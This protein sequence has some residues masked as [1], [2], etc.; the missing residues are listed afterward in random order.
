MRLASPTPRTSALQPRTRTPLAFWI[1]GLLLVAYV[2]LCA[3]QRDTLWE[4]DGWEHQRA[5]VVL[6]RHLWNPGNPTYATAQPSVRYSPYSV[7]QALLAR[8]TGL[9][10]YTLLSIAAVINTLLLIIGLWCLLKSFGESRAAAA[11]LVVIVG[12]YGAAPGYAGSY[13]LADLPW[14]Q[15]NP[16][17]FSFAL[18]LLAL[19]LFKWMTTRPPGLRL[20][21]GWL[22]LIMLM[23]TATLDHGMNGL[24]GMCV[25]MLIALTRPKE[26]RW[27]WGAAV[28]GVGVAAALVCLAWPWYS[29]WHAVTGQRDNAYWYNRTI[30]V[31]MLVR[32]CAPALLLSLAA[33]LLRRR[34]MVRVFLLGGAICYVIGAIDLA[35][36]SPVV[37]RFPLPGLILLDLPIAIFIHECGLLRPATWPRRCRALLAGD[38]DGAARAILEVMVAAVLAWCL[39]PQVLAVPHSP[40]LARAYVA[41]LIGAKPKIEHIH[42]RMNALL[43][44]VGPRDVVLSDPKTSWPIPASRGRIVAAIHYELFVPDQEQRMA[45]VEAFFSPA[46][47]DARRFEILHRYQV[48]W[49]VLNRQMIDRMFD[50]LLEEHAVVKRNGDLVLMNADAWEALRRQNERKG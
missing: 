31:L 50:D 40:H 12:L 15:V 24:F 3:G 9:D 18:V 34:E 32:W 36:H 4:I 7:A 43:E 46:T 45:D 29:F 39:A 13:A 8:A 49:I 17:A 48:R 23:A 6:T 1:L 28:V 22:A 16:S 26:M 30:L 35:F 19:A 47:P 27:R 20:A 10:A 33:L 38:T 21:W 5:I 42:P 14:L 25:L 37:A 41:P 2:A 44:P 11:A